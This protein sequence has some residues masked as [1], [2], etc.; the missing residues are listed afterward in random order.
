M[1]ALASCD[2]GTGDKVPSHLF[3]FP[4]REVG[5]ARVSMLTPSPACSSFSFSGVLSGSLPPGFGE[6][7]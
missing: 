1:A 4:S 3:I 6:G 2:R 7:V 5:A